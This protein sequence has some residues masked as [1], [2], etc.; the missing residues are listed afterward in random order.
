MKRQVCEPPLKG[1]PGSEIV[2]AE[3]II[4]VEGDEIYTSS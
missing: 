1:M 3:V 4:E 2:N